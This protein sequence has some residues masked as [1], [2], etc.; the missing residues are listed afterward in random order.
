MKDLEQIENLVQ[1]YNKV[2]QRIEKKP[3]RLIATFMPM[4]ADAQH[5]G[6]NMTA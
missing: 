2:Q 1:E 6:T 5:V 4:V 3:K